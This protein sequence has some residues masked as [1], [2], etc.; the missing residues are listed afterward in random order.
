[1]KQLLISLLL[2]SLGINAYYLQKKVKERNRWNEESK[3]HFYK[4]I[5]Y[6]DGYDYF[7]KQ[8][9]TKYPETSLTNKYVIVYRWDSLRYEI[10][11][12]EQMMALDSMAAN[13]GKYSLEYVFVTEM[14]EEPSRKFLKDNFANFKNVKML[15]GM[16][17]YISSIFNIKGLKFMKPTMSPNL[18]KLG[19]E[20]PFLYYK[21]SN[22]YTIIDS[23]GKVL[24][25]NENRLSVLKDS[26]FLN[27]L[28]FV[29]P[30]QNVK[31][32]N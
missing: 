10:F 29:L 9:K 21:Q 22:L 24:Y 19:H 16:D 28:K 2:I 6:E 32:L 18:L 13:F 5:S 14:E 27:K 17:D 12:Q 11:F 8:L 4:K 20:N 3:L 30:K 31:I 7:K 1:M 23:E 15:F 25:V 26:A